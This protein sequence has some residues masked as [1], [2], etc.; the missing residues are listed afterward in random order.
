VQSR[1]RVDQGMPFITEAQP[2]RDGST[3]LQIGNLAGA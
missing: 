2:A 1:Q 3:I